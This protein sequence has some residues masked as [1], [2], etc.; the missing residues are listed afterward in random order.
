MC[1][2]VFGVLEKTPLAFK[3]N[4]RNTTFFSFPSTHD[5]I[6]FLFLQLII[7]IV[8]MIMGVILICYM[9]AG[10]TADMTNSGIHKA[11]FQEKI[12]VAEGYL[13]VRLNFCVKFAFGFIL[14]IKC[15]VE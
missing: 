1:L 10:I 3:N 11:S 5:D 7:S 4:L 8:A 12:E 6:I 13:K 9:I 2:T 14:F 15:L